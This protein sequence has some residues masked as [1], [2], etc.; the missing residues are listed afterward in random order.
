MLNLFLKI[1]S[2]VNLL[3][4]LHILS[5]PASANN[6]TKNLPAPALLCP[7]DLK[8]A[9]EAVINRP[10]FRRSRW[11]ILVKPL[12]SQSPLYALDAQRYFT[13]AS[14][15]K[16]LTTAAALLEL[17]P[18]FQIR[19]SVYGTSYTPNV[20]SLRVAG[21]GDPTLTDAKLEDL[22]QQLKRQ[23]IANVA[24]LVIEDGY[25]PGPSI[26]PTW[27]WEDIH[28][29]Y[30]VAVN[31]A[32]L[33]QNAFAIAILPQ[34]LGQPVKLQ[35]SDSVAVRQ[36]RIDNQ[37]VSAPAGTPYGIEILGD[38]GQPVLKVAGE[39]AIDAKPDIWRLA[40]A[41]PGSYFL[42]SFRRILLREGITVING[43]VVTLSESTAAKQSPR[44]SSEIELAAI[45]SPP[46]AVL[47]QETNQESN[48]L[49]AEVLLRLL[50]TASSTG[51]E[52]SILKQKLSELGVN[53]SSY[54]LVDGSGLSRHNLLSPEAV[55]QTLQ[56][57]AQSPYAEVY[58][59]SL[60]AAGI[61]GTLQ[62]RFQSTPVQ[63]NLRAKTGTLSGVSV[64]SGHLDIPTYQPLVFSIMLNH[65]DQSVKIQRAAIDE[66]VLILS[67][68]RFC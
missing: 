28:A 55:V 45:D 19:T 44:H 40:V 49:F 13:P 38:L 33:N 8:A 43:L 29:D 18:Q 34:E 20:T 42:E 68:L 2:S 66:I 30:G 39:L 11:G 17:G 27:E 59:A 51:D 5:G 62:R 37:A 64:L 67:R 22:A 12:A 50:G 63:G 36:W 14:N 52:L 6:T 3:I 60:P 4:G 31:S 65:S 57:M 48:N 61:S 32:I 16:L 9:I 21:R 10:Q 58:R 56:L 23:G 41:D 47:L 46:L 54:L 26:N 25:L 35:W 1:V 15:V 53:P 7:A 24:R